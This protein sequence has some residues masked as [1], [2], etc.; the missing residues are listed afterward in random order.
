MNIHY[1]DPINPGDILCLPRQGMPVH[2]KVKTKGD[3][4]IQFNVTFPAKIT[5]QQKAVIMKA[6]HKTP[7]PAPTGAVPLQKMKPKQQQQK[8]DRPQDDD[9]EQG[10]G[11]PGVQCAQQ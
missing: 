3:L 9:D 1:P 6:F 7:Q 4:F 11:G 10:Q 5:D 2:G 8:Y